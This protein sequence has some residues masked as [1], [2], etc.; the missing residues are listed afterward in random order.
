MFDRFGIRAKTLT[1]IT[2]ALTASATPVTK[3]PPVRHDPRV[4]NLDGRAVKDPCAR[5][6]VT[7]LLEARKNKRYRSQEM[8]QAAT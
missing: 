3:P 6:A 4:L 7:L 8:Y 1:A 5:Y 2:H